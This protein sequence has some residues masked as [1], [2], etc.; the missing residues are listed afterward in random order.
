[1]RKQSNKM[2]DIHTHV[3]H[4]MDDGPAKLED[5]IS[6]IKKLAQTGVDTVAATSHYY[7]IVESPEKYVSKRSASLDLVTKRLDSEGINVRIIPGAE[8]LLNRLIL[9]QSDIRELCYNKGKH[10]LLEISQKNF[11]FD[12]STEL[13]ERIM[14]YYNV[15]PVIAH[16]ERYPFFVKN[17]RW[18]EYL[19][20]MGCLIQLDSSCFLDGFMEKHFGFKLFKKNLADVVGS[21]CHNM[22]TRGP[23]LDLAYNVIEKKLGADT[24]E[25]LKYN[26]D[27]IVNN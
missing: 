24:V 12:E 16:V 23:N 14:S 20:D 4:G 13:I 26:A 15:V 11:D 3:L 9:N 22:V 27:F 21:D 1:M 18:L 19:K 5:S 2:T 6:L 17:I 25:M 10:I 7:P 8:V